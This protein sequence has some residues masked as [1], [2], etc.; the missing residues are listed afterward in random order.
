MVG[1]ATVNL[2]TGAFNVSLSG[3]TPLTTYTVWLVDRTESLAIPPIPGDRSVRTGHLPGPRPDGPPERHPAVGEPAVRLHARRRRGLNRAPPG[4][5][6]AGRRHGEHLPEDLLQ[7]FESGEREHR[8]GPLRR[9]DAAAEPLCARSGSR[10]RDR[11]DR[12]A[13]SDAR[14]SR[15]AWSPPAVC[16]LH[17]AARNLPPHGLCERRQPNG[18]AAR[19]NSTS[20]SRRAR[21]SFSRRRSTATAAP[22]A[23]VIPPTTT[24]RSIRPSSRRGRRTIRCSWRS[25]TLRWR[26]S[27]SRR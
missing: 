3:L 17:A 20:S 19:S 25:S 15:S 24:S 10:G 26:S 11:C 13:R 16:P 2:E 5:S 1:E 7:T 4:R 14:P 18:P 23:P 27:K 21:S 6:G 22:A 8:C 9:A 12:V